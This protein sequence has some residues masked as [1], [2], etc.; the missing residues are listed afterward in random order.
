VIK[1]TS[2][3]SVAIDNRAISDWQIDRSPG[4]V[5]VY[6]K[7]GIVID[8]NPAACRILRQSREELIGKATSDPGWLV[9]ESP[10]GPT[11]DHP[12]AVALKSRAEERGYLIRV[13]RPG[14]GDTWL[15]CD[16]VP[17]QGAVALSLTDVSHLVVSTRT[18]ADSTLA[19]IEYEFADARLEV[20][21]ILD[22]VVE[23]LGAARPG[24]WIALVVGRDPGTSTVVVRDSLEPALTRYLETYFESRRGLTSAPKSGI[25]QRV[26]DSGKTLRLNNASL[27]ELIA[28]SSDAA[29]EF[30]DAHRIPV[31]I[32]S[33]DVMVVPMRAGGATI[34]TLGLFERRSSNPLTDGDVAWLQAIA[35]RVGLAV[36]N[37]QLYEDALKRLDRLGSLAS[38]A[39]ALRTSSDLKLTMKLI[40]DQAVSRLS[41]DAAD[42]LAVE[43]SDN[44]L[45]SIASAGFHA[46]V[47]PEYRVPVSEALPGP[48]TDRRIE[49]VTVLGGFSQSR[50]RSL[51]ARE[52][53]RAYGAVPLIARDRLV[54]VLEVFHRSPLEPDDEWLT[55][56][57]ALGS[58]A[59]IAIDNATAHESLRRVG[60][61]T[62]RLRKPELSDLEMQMLGLLVE[63][64]TNAEIAADVHLSSSS[65]KFHVRQILDKT[66]AA[67]R[68]DLTHMATREGWV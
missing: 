5:L 60:M 29:R 64:K 19:Q 16:A 3:P 11:S 18:T 66:G 6:D 52:G 25:S 13:R 37:A 63:G 30:M 38:V 43:E 14:A 36:Q 21:E 58:E 54:G 53:F 51:F 32:G 39:L 9:T 65:V 33:V 47:L 68:V 26:I 59:A 12:V 28:I 17:G 20:E 2:I 67:N 57:D 50:R 40:L 27:E 55:F 7:R 22:K 10:A 31:E 44:T 46:T 61:A 42:V 35:D 62:T 48:L 34:G 8:A 23:K 24:M 4:A 49:T 1:L 15:L 41:V 56:L 45:I